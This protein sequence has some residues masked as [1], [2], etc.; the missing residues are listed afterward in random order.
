M[1]ESL[2]FSFGFVVVAYA[3]ESGTSKSL[4]GPDKIISV[5]FTSTIPGKKKTPASLA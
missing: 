1:I 4:P 3:G 5:G 2:S